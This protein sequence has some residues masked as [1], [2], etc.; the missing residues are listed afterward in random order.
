[1]N[2]SASGTPST[3]TISTPTIS[4]PTRGPGRIVAKKAIELPRPR[5]LALTYTTAFTDI[6]LELREH[7]GAIRKPF[8]VA[9]AELAS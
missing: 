3:P 9:A 4:A 6:V 5:D 2:E 8:V 7:I 1:M